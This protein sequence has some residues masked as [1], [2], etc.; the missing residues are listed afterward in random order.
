M[1]MKNPSGKNLYCNTQKSTNLE[2]KAIIN[3]VPLTDTMSKK[4][5][6]ATQWFLSEKSNL[7]FI[8]QDLKV[9]V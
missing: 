5:K 8:S 2:R 1:E 6:L 7:S 9:L 4:Y 3:F